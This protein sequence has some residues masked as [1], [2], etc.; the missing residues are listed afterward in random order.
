MANKNTKHNRA[1]IR[2]DG[3]DGSIETRLSLPAGGYHNSAKGAFVTKS[4]PTA[5]RG[6]GGVN[7][8]SPARNMRQRILTNEGGGTLTVHEPI[9]ES[10]PVTF[11]NHQYMAQDNAYFQPKGLK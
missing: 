2:K 8:S 3:K 9:D 11:K 1:A 5:R 6:A 10:R 4:F 7:S